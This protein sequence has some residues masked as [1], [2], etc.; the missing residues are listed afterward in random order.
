MLLALLSETLLVAAHAATGVWVLLFQVQSLDV[1][2]TGSARIRVGP[3]FKP[4]LA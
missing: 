3:R 4:A 2:L 1:R